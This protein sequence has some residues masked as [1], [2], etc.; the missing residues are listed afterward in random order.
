MFPCFWVSIGET[1]Y[2]YKIV[3]TMTFAWPQLS[4]QGYNPF[5]RGFHFPLVF[6]LFQGYPFSKGPYPFS[7]IPTP[8]KVLILHAKEGQP[9]VAQPLLAGLSLHAASKKLS[10]PFPRLWGLTWQHMLPEASPSYPKP[11]A[12]S[13]DPFFPMIFDVINGLGKVWRHAA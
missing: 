12:L 2:M 1:Y 7:R 10:M 3:V 9:A 6:I 4:F 8:R 13:T 5:P 11:L